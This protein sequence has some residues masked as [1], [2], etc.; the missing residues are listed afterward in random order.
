ML[1]L[2][3]G[4]LCFIVGFSGW[5]RKYKY[6]LVKGFW[7]SQKIALI[8]FGLVWSWVYVKPLFVFYVIFLTV[9]ICFGVYKTKLEKQKSEQSSNTTMHG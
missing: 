8:V 1:E 6:L 9:A 2:I 3:I 7:L 5:E 4:L